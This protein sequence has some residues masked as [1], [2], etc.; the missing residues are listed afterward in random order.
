MTNIFVLTPGRTGSTTFAKACTHIENYSVG[1]ETNS[2]II[3]PE[4]L[5][6][7]SQHIE[8]DS[9]LLWFLTSLKNVYSENTKFAYL[10][11]DPIEVA[12][13]YSERWNNPVSI[14]RAF[15]EGIL[16]RPNLQ[17]N[18]RLQVCLQYASLA[19]E[20]ILDFIRKN[21]GIVVELQNITIDF[22]RFFDWISAE[23]NLEHCMSEFQIKYNRN[24]KK[25]VLQVLERKL[26][27]THRIIK[28]FMTDR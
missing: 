11:R 18:E 14:V 9:R 21:D 8:V 7:P 2:Q 25:G 28:K 10:R 27:T 12:S 17:N 24:E 3:G 5:K 15:G 16:M 4:R 19:D 1:Q 20:I 26:Q 22:P 13:S 6:Y 23:G